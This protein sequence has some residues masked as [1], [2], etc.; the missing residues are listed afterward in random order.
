TRSHPGAEKIGANITRDKARIDFAWEG[1]IS[2]VF[3]F[4]G[5]E[6]ERLVQADRPIVSRFRDVATQTRYWEIE[7]FARVACGGTHPRSTGE[8]G[9]IRLKRANPGR[10]KERIEIFLAAG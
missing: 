7:G 1:N 5:R 10:G 8:V 4:L 2:Q 9:G 6:I 3:P